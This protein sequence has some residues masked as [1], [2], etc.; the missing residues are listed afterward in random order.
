MGHR[1]RNER[2]MYTVA[3]LGELAPVVHAEFFSESVEITMLHS[4]LKKRSAPIFRHGAAS[5]AARASTRGSSFVQSSDSLQVILAESLKGSKG[6]RVISE[7][8][9]ERAMLGWEFVSPW[10][11][12]S[13]GC[14]CD[15]EGA[16]RMRCDGGAGVPYI[17]CCLSLQSV[18]EGVS[19]GRRAQEGRIYS[20]RTQLEAQHQGC[21]R[22]AHRRICEACRKRRASAA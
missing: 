19:R 3:V 2:T 9:S 4:S 5:A 18:F 14:T 17:T 10:L 22:H 13:G 8:L 7:R 16:W 21:P 11:L 6:G 20:Q 15:V 1:R 12:D